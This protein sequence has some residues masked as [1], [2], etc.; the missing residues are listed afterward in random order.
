MKTLDCKFI[1]IFNKY[2]ENK[3]L[4]NNNALNSSIYKIDELFLKSK[5]TSN[6][7]FLYKSIDLTYNKNKHKSQFFTYKGY[8]Q[9]FLLTDLHTPIYK[10]DK[11]K[12]ILQINIPIGS[13]II[14]LNDNHVLLN[15]NC[16]ISIVSIDKFII[17]VDY[18]N[19]HTFR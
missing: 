3:C 1:K 19:L 4:P 14:F 9:G 13:N 2:L 8:Y 15:R 7:M 11:P 10:T 6:Q 16:I 17:N 12:I 5:P 18:N